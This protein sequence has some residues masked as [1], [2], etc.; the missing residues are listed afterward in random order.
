V[1]YTTR[2]QLFEVRESTPPSALRGGVYRRFTKINHAMANLKSLQY[3][4]VIFHI[5][6]GLIIVNRIVFQKT[7]SIQL[8]EWATKTTNDYKSS[9][10]NPWITLGNYSNG[11]NINTGT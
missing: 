3:G 2:P 8:L 7:A 9:S 10:T 1:I 6:S 4:G 5:E 11:K